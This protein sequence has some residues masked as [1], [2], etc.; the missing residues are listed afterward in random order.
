MDAA[1]VVEAVGEHV[2]GMK[3]GDRVYTAGTLTGS[4]A[5]YA[6][7]DASQVYPLADRIGF[8]EGAGIYV[9]YAT[10]YR[11]L[12]QKAHARAGQTVLV[13]GASG[14]VG[15]A[16]V[17][18][19]RAMGLVLTGSA[20]TKEGREHVL[21]Q[22]AHNV[23][24]HSKENYL[25]AAVAELTQGRGFDL[26]IEMLSNVNLDKDLGALAVNGTV[27]VIGSRGRVEI[28]PRKSMSRE[29]TI[30]GMT[31]MNANEQELTE[32]HAALHAGF[33]NG[34]LMPVVGQKFQ[35]S[36]AAQAHTAIMQHGAQGKIVLM[37]A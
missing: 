7:C 12:V 21:R 3:P 8:A 24:D 27:V 23:I 34:T 36:E 4:Y 16:A 22:G 6:L 26:I 5:E 33:T 13:H 35:L 37:V 2:T 10:A 30:H 19:G 28:D 14:G 15:T 29:L 11:A 17:Q 18:I 32:I 9:P 25:D 31:L 20:G 1:G